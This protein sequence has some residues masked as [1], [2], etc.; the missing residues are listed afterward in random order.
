MLIL[1]RKPG[2]QI[3]LNDDITITVVSAKGSQ[4]RIGIEAPKSVQ[5]HRVEL[6]K[7]DA[8]DG[9]QDKTLATKEKTQNN[10]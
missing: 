5:I 8:E 3:R 6:E 7:R 1:T 9:G 2:D 4:V 10:R